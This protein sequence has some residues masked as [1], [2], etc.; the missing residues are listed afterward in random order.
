MDAVHPVNGNTDFDGFCFGFCFRFHQPFLFEEAAQGLLRLFVITFDFSAS[1]DAEAAA[2]KSKGRS[3]CIVQFFV[4]VEGNQVFRQF[5]AVVQIG[6][7]G[8]MYVPPFFVSTYITLNS[9]NSKL[10]CI[11]GRNYSSVSGAISP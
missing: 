4:M 9:D 1:E 11:F 8:Y 7:D 3:S 10:F 6:F 2:F 5:L